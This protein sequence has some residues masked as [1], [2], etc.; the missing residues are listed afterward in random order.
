MADQL[1][2]YDEAHISPDKMARYALN[3]DHTD[4]KDK[5]HVLRA[6]FDYGPEDADRLREQLLAGL[7][8]GTVTG[9]RETEWGRRYCV[10]I[11]VRGNNDRTANVETVWQV[12]ETT[13]RLVTVRSIKPPTEG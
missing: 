4:G 10:E 11:P 12:E 5:A 13:L 3:G 8:D 7:A 1:P 9:T 6:V 2:P